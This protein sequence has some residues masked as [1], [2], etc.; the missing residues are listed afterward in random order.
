MPSARQDRDDTACRQMKKVKKNILP[1]EIWFSKKW[2][3]SDRIGKSSFEI[4]Y[5]RGSRKAAWGR[6]PEVFSSEAQGGKSSASREGN[7]LRPIQLGA[8]RCTLTTIS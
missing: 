6:G 4:G 1:Q 2:E 8:R 7:P 3:C 5:A